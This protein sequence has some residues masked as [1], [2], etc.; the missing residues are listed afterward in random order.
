MVKCQKFLAKERKSDM[1]FYFLPV[2]FIFIIP[3]CIYLM[4]R[5][6]SKQIAKL[7][8]ENQKLWNEIKWDKMKKFVKDDEMDEAYLQFIESL[9]N[10]PYGKGYPLE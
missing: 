6:E 1:F 7:I 5:H 4:W 10:T 2:L 3:G 8:V 9:P